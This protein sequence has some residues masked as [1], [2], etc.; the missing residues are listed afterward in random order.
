MRLQPKEIKAISEVFRVRMGLEPAELYLFGSRVDGR[1]RGGD[2]D[3]L[4]LASSNRRSW[5]LEQ[6]AVIQD[7]ICRRI[8]DQ[9]ID[10][11]VASPEAMAT[12]PFLRS[13]SQDKVRLL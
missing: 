11:T 6:K 9:R 7:E 2:I 1:K 4:I 12:D 13:I 5:W 3:L 8:G 10:I